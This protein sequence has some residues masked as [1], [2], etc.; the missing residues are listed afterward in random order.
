[1]RDL[2]ATLIFVKVVECG[3]FSGAANALRLPKTTVS[4][5][6]QELEAWLGAPL[7]HRTT[8]KLGLTEIGNAYFE[9]C[10]PLARKLDEAEQVV[11]QLQ[12]APRGWLRLTAPYAIGVTWI[13]PL[14]G[15]FYALYP[16]LRIEM[17]LSNANLDLIDAGIDIALRVGNLPDSNLVARHLAAFPSHIYASPAYIE[18]CGQPSHP[19]ELRQH[20]TLAMD[21]AR[22]TNND[23]F[24]TLSNGG[25]S[26]DFAIDP[27]LVANGTASLHSALRSGAGLMLAS[28]VTVKQ[29]AAQGSV[30]RVLPSWTGPTLDLN[31]VFARE[32]TEAPKVRAFIDFLVEYLNFETG[33]L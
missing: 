27:V 29:D 12:G 6:V 2:N 31:V 25:H 7:L 5:K 17:V 28:D 26:G 33:H 30:Q 15:N 21:T 1:M 10:Q 19:N 20:R 9:R 23:Y 13:A 18:R 16:E 32:Q 3:S 4:R 14:L 11:S 24:W 8:R 22:R